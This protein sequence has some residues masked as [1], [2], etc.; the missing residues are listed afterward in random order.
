MER[1]KREEK[2]QEKVFGD[3]RS[4][5]GSKEIRLWLPTPT[6]QASWGSSKAQ[7]LGVMG[8]RDSRSRS[9]AAGLAEAV[10]AKAF[11]PCALH[12]ATSWL[13]RKRSCLSAPLAERETG[14]NLRAFL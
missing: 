4:I 14:G 1:K 9:G 12:P 5:L 13:Q 8:L 11:S 3:K 10:R 6:T 7:S 2:Q